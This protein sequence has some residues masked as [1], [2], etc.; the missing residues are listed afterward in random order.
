[1]SETTF[2]TLQAY[3]EA[4][5][6]VLERAQRTIDCLD[7]DLARSALPG[8]RAVELLGQFL[9]AR[10]DARLRLLLHDSGHLARHCPRLLDLYRQRGHQITI[11]ELAEEHRREMRVFVSAD[12]RDLATR[13]HAAQARGKLALDAAPVAAPLDELFEG[14]LQAAQTPSGL[15]ILQ[16]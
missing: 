15:Q 12:G 7:T 10:R 13:F 5:I 6:Q 11:A 4:V 16:I 1:M 9:N 2:D 8:A 14:L 3:H